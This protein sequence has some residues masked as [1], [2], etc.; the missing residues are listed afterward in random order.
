MQPQGPSVAF[1]LV[2][3]KKKKQINIFFTCQEW[4]GLCISPVYWVF[5][6][7]QSLLLVWDTSDLSKKVREKIYRLFQGPGHRKTIITDGLIE[8]NCD[9]QHF[10]LIQYVYFKT[11]AKAK[12]NQCQVF[13]FRL[14]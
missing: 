13:I 11:A 9:L 3:F 6:T 5:N 8:L 4:E 1:I 7:C 12:E 2:L 14:F 10:C